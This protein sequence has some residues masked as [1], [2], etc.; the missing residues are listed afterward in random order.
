MGEIENR[1]VVKQNG[2]VRNEMNKQL[3]TQWI[4]LEDLV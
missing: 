4:K 2:K 3:I 1:R